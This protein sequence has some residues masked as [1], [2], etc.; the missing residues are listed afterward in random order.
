MKKL[1]LLWIISL[2][3][4]FYGASPVRIPQKYCNKENSILV[5]HNEWTCSA[6]FDIIEGDLRIPNALQNTKFISTT[7]ITVSG[8]TP[9]NYT[10]NEFGTIELLSSADF[11]LTGHVI[12]VDS[13]HNGGCGKR[14]LFAVES[15]GM[16]KYFPRF[17]TFNKTQMIM[18]ILVLPL[19]FF[20]L[21]VYTIMSLKKIYSEK[22]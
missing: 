10:V 22:E 9:L 16:T 11:I 13:T 20:G 1:K 2:L 5:D 7:E 8:N 3:F 12:G 21:I 14:P 6:D 19:T 15:W 18:F 17:W 4:L